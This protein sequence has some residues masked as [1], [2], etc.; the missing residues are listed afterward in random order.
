VFFER[1]RNAWFENC[2]QT[3]AEVNRRTDASIKIASRR[4]GGAAD[5]ALRAYQL[6]QA[7]R[8]MS[9]KEYVPPSDGR[10]FSDLLWAQVCGTYLDDVIGMVHRYKES[11]KQPKERFAE[12]ERFA[13]DVAHYITAESR[14]AHALTPG[15]MMETPQLTAHTLMIVARAFGD[16]ETFEDIEA[17]LLRKQNE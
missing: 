16:K 13:L 2:L 1:D 6:M 3:I 8:L 4:M 14:W 7:A 5:L 11:K 17:Q 10:D 15:L 12:E 9:L